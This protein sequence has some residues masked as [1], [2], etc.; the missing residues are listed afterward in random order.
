MSVAARKKIIPRAQNQAELQILPK[1]KRSRHCSQVRV[2]VQTQQG[3][4]TISRTARI[5]TQGLQKTK[6]NDLDLLKVYTQ[7][8]EVLSGSPNQAK[9]HDEQYTTAKQRG[10]AQTSGRATLGS[11]DGI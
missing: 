4:D 10:V 2:A 5:E 11:D 7:L 6:L 9:L 1:A 8:E 3:S